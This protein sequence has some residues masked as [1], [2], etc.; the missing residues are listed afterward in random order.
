MWPPLCRRA[1]SGRARLCSHPLRAHATFLSL[2]DTALDQAVADGFVSHTGDGTAPLAAS[3]GPDQIVAASGGELYEGNAWVQLLDPATDMPYYY[4]QLTQAV[5]WEPPAGFD[6]THFY[7]RW[8]AVCGCQG[9]PRRLHLPPPHA[10][11]GPLIPFA[12]QD[13]ADECLDEA[14]SLGEQCVPRAVRVA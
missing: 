11:R 2:H 9:G 8:S 3:I 10:H 14:A 13:A 4:N 7:V 12:S 5:Q 6:D 1:A